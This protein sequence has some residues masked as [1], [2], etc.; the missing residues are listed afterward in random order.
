MVNVA[1][2]IG[3]C[4]GVVLFFSVLADSVPEIGFGVG[5]FLFLF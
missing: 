1:G 3:Y 2:E 4:L 5:S